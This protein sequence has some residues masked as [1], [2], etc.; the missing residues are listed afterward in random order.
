MARIQFAQQGFWYTREVFA[1]HPWQAGA[2][3]VNALWIIS[4]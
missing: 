1:S 2:G 4:S 3:C